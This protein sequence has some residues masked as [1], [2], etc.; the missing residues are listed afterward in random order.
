METKKQI[1]KARNSGKDHARALRYAMA[2]VSFEEVGAREDRNLGHCKDVVATIKMLCEEETGYKIS[3]YQ[4]TLDF[5]KSNQNQ[6]KELAPYTLL[7]IAEIQKE[8]G[9]KD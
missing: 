2:L 1:K 6:L 5:L 8:E 7:K 3:G 9:G 4:E